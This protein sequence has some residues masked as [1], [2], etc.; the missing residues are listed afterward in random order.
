MKAKELQIEKKM[1]TER[2][3]P[4]QIKA[5]LGQPEPVLNFGR[6]TDKFKSGFG[7]DGAKIQHKKKEQDF[8]SSQ[9]I[10]AKQFSHL[11]ER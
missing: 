8:S 5:Q 3:T 11:S 2:G 1:M 10:D 7:K 4:A 6:N 9:K